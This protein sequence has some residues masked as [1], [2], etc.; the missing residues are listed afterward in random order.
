MALSH[1]SDA[2]AFGTLRKQLTDGSTL[3]PRE[4]AILVCAQARALGDSY[5]AMAWGTR[6]AELIDAKSGA[7]VLR[8]LDAPD[9]SR[10]LR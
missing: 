2:E 9:L 4:R 7:D 10:K 8:G 3:S 5:C 1:R 6:L